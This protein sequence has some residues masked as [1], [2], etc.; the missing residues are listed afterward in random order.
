MAPD[1]ELISLASGEDDLDF[2]VA[3]TGIADVEAYF[4]SLNA[5][6]EMSH[7]TINDYVAENDRVV[8]VGS[9][10]WTSRESGKSFDTPHV[11]VAQFR[12]GK[13]VE[14]TEYYNTAMVAK[15]L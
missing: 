6:F 13:I 4:S 8:A 12:D 14:L 5:L 10:A 15:A 3:R 7:F 11:L 9:T 1:I 2:T